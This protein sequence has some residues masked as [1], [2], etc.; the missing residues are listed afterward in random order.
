[1]KTIELTD[2]EHKALIFIVDNFDAE[3]IED[4]EYDDLQDSISTKL[5]AKIES[6]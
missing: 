2:E 4:M 3:W 5:E 6:T 1:M